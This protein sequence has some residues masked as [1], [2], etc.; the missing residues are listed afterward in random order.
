MFYLNTAN[1]APCPGNITSWRVCY[2]QPI[3]QVRLRMYWATYAVYRKVGS[4][5][6]EQYI[7]VSAVYRAVRATTNLLDVISRR[8]RSSTRF[9]PIDGEAL[10][11]YACYN[12]SIDVGG[13]P[14]TVQAGDVVGACVFDPLDSSRVVQYQLDI[15]SEVN[16]ESLLAMASTAAGCNIETLPSTIPANQ[17]SIIHARLHLYA[18]IGMFYT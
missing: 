7:R 11:G 5:A 13:S 15:V 17:L 6:A 3:D 8:N 2:Y 12:D 1:P 18:N 14:L 16:G 9:A 4:G 10:D